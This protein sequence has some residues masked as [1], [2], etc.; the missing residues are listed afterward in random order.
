[1]NLDVWMDV[2]A[3]V[4]EVPAQEVYRIKRDLVN[5]FA[6]TDFKVVL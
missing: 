3:V 2:P 6:L 5:N 1:M 4:I